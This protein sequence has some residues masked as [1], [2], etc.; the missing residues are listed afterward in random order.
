MCEKTMSIWPKGCPFRRM[1]PVVAA[2]E[3]SMC[4]MVASD[5]LLCE[6][7]G[8]ADQDA[9]GLGHALD[10]QAGGHEGKGREQVVQVLFRQGDVLDRDG[11]SARLEGGELV[12]P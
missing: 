4:S 3:S 12:N 6:V 1:T 8:F 9:G 10:D 5:D 11:A 2:A 7:A